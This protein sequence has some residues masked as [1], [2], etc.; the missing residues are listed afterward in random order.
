MNI[1]NNE[2][3]TTCKKQR[4]MIGLIISLITMLMTMLTTFTLATSVV[5][6]IPPR[7]NIEIIGAKQVSNTN[8][9]GTKENWGKIEKNLVH[10]EVLNKVS[11]NY[12]YIDK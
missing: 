10:N 8:Y 11:V 12:N 5:D 4:N 3:K 1:K 7:G 9:I 2:Q 6:V